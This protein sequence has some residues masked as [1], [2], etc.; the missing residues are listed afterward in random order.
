[1]IAALSHLSFN[2]VA[3]GESGAFR[4]LGVI[5]LEDDA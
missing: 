2:P 1:M 5:R 4:N 3:I